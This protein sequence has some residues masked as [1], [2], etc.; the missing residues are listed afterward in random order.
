MSESLDVLS[1]DVLF[2]MMSES[3]DIAVA[4][5]LTDVARARPAASGA[6]G[7]FRRGRAAAAADGRG[8]GAAACAD[9]GERGERGRRPHAR[10]RSSSSSSAVFRI[11]F[12]AAPASTARTISTR[13]RTSPAFIRSP[14]R[15][16]A[17]T[18]RLRL[19][20]MRA[21]TWN[22]SRSCRRLLR[23]RRATPGG[24]ARAWLR[25]AAHRSRARGRRTSA[26]RMAARGPAH[27]FFERLRSGL[28]SAS[29]R[30]ALPLL[31]RAI[32]NHRI[33]DCGR[34]T[35][36]CSMSS[37]RTS[38]SGGS[39]SAAAAGREETSSMRGG[40]RAHDE[41][42]TDAGEGA[43]DRARRAQATARG[44]ARAVRAS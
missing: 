19:S 10:S 42:V 9:S 30:D 11:A 32:D 20:R 38:R 35:P 1:N 16:S 8:M 13:S 22:G 28:S 26:A 25:C 40:S 6:A 34:P 29:P 14:S 4:L 21:A 3:P 15:C 36:R 27:L 33:R 31:E 23:M 2:G 24:A 37:M 18:I 5:G 7:L 41:P 39:P 17:A 43:R 44:A 12:R